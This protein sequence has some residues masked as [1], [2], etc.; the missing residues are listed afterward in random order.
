MGNFN[1]DIYMEG[2]RLVTSFCGDTSDMYQFVFN[3]ET[4]EF[5]DIIPCSARMEFDIDKDGWYRVVI[6]KKAGTVLVNGAIDTGYTTY[7]SE[8]IMEHI[9]SERDDVWNPEYIGDY[10][11][12]DVF[13]ICKLKKCLAEL[14]LK[15]F[16][17]M[18][19]NCGKVI[20]R[21]DDIKSQRDFLFIA[22]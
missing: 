11:I 5:S 1:K 17:D 10:E 22:V 12:S 20:C 3:P 9:E 15:V 4:A 7:T 13:S 6:F 16:Q 14:E 18:L 8:Y 2:C 21:N 19:K